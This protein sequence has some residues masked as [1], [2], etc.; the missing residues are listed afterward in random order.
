V[1]E[2]HAIGDAEIRT[3]HTTVTPSQVVAFGAGLYLLI[4]CGKR[5]SRTHLSSLLWPD[6]AA[7]ARAHRLRQTVYQLRALG[8]PI[9][10]D[11]DFVSVAR[12]DV[13]TDYEGVS[14]E[15]IS[16]ER[17]RNSFEFLPGYFPRFSHEFDAWLDTTRE[18]VHASLTRALLVHLQQSR[19][20]AAWQAVEDV[21]NACLKLDPYN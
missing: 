20:G 9:Y 8:F 19:N 5:T 2:L 17:V 12:E 18:R 16:A 11:R 3:N 13:L 7:N 15:S 1:I 10:A 6:A 14:G 21:A 4:E